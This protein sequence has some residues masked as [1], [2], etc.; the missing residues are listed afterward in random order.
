[1]LVNKYILEKYKK[2]G[3]KYYF[4]S[5]LCY[6]DIEFSLAT[7]DLCPS[8]DIFNGLLSPN[9]QMDT[10]LIILLF[11]YKFIIKMTTSM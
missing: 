3:W 7:Y 4:K 11:F 1:M 5:L 9:H 6:V 2:F 8:K 10:L